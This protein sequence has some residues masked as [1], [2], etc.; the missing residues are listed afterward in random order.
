[1]GMEKPCFLPLQGGTARFRRGLAVLGAVA[2]GSAFAGGAG[3]LELGMPI[4]CEVGESCWVVN[5]VDIDSGPEW[6]DYAC[7]KRNYD[8]HTGVDIA[9]RD[10]AAMQT[11]VP[12]LAA[13]PG[14]VKAVRDGMPDKM[15]D[16]DF[17]RRFKHLYCGNG[18]VVSHGDGWETQYCHLRRGSL[19][20]EAGDRIK[21]GQKLGLVG[22]SGK[23]EF[24]HVHLA[25]RQRGKVVDPF[26]GVD[27]ATKRKDP[28]GP[29]ASA[30]WN[31]AALSALTR[32]MTAVFNAGFAAE[33]PKDRAI[34]AGLYKAKALSRRSPVLIFWAETWWV[35]KGDRLELSIA[36][37]DGAVIVKHASELPKRQARRMVFAGRKK[38][39]L[40][41]RAGTYTGIA[42]LTRRENGEIRQFEA[43]RKIVLRD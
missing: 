28:C 22:H 6:R 2:F 21:R 8:G 42:R 31:G 27:G 32:P 26:L 13:A 37:P 24:P 17:R 16:D 39:A 33:K 11:G 20:V 25:A 38:P 3:A 4:D 34:R 29:S 35:R 7:G 43:R 9:I 18:L 5:L 1:M 41:W 14:V 10:L 15:P 12:V 19:L 23:A 40:F 30:L 36:G